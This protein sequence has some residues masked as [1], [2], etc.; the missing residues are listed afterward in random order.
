MN[1]DKEWETN[2]IKVLSERNSQLYL[3]LSKLLTSLDWAGLGGR[4][5]DLSD[6]IREAK[7]VLNWEQNFENREN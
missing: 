6:S 2:I 7:A 5:G 3:A 1:T 4:A